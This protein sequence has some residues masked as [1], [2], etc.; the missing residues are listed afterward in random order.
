MCYYN[1]V[2]VKLKEISGLIE[3]TKLIENFERDLQSGFE[4]QLFPVAMKKKGHT[5]GE[6]AHWEFIPFWY[7]SMKEVEEGR[8]KYTTLNAQGE[9]LL[10]SKIYK[11]AAHE[12]R[13]LVL[14]SG[15][16]EWRHYKGVAYPYHIRLKDRETFYMAGIYRQWTD[17]LSGETLNTTAIVTTDAN[18]LMKQVHN[19]KERMPVILNDE[20]ASIKGFK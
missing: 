15:F 11:E 3:D 5:K 20:L 16:Y 6:L 9:K 2:K 13:C 10:T 19:S 18:P 4:Y 1:G 14:S 7:K 8:K 12:R 17:E